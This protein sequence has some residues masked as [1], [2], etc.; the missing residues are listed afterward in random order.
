MGVAAGSGAVRVRSG[1]TFGASCRW[2][3]S[4]WIILVSTGRPDRYREESA[5]A[6]DVHATDG[7]ESA[8]PAPVARRTAQ[9][10][11]MPPSA[12]RLVP[13][14]GSRWVCGVGEVQKSRGSADLEHLHL[15]AVARGFGMTDGGKP[16]AAS[17]R[18]I[19]V[20]G[21]GVTPSRWRRK[22]SSSSVL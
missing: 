5:G 9:Q 6:V 18:A 12:G 22:I 1:S 11:S 13:Q 8:M 19:V 10:S 20:P 7:E 2:C 16:M 21:G 15:C 4:A 17:R 3:P 14:R